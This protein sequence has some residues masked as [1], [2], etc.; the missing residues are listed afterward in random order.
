MGVEKRLYT[1]MTRPRY[2]LLF[3]FSIALIPRLLVWTIIPID[4]NSDSYHHW[5]ISYLTLKIGLKQGRLWD[6]NGCEFYWGVVPHLVQAFILGALFTPSLLPYR[7]LNLM[8]GCVNSYLVYLIG[9]D[10]FYWEVGFYAGILFALYPVAAVFD[11]VALQETLALCLALL[12]IQLFKS[13]PGLSG[14]LLALA[15]QSRTEFWLVSVF[16]V[17]GVVL[18]ER[19]TMRVQPFV[20]GWLAVTSLFCA[21]FRNWTSNPFYPLYW[22]LYNVF[23]GWTQ[24]GR[25]LPFHTLMLNWI[26]DKIQ[27]WLAKATGQ[28]LLGSMITL[29]G[30][31]L[32][33]LR[34][35]WRR[36][37]VYLFFL[38]VAVVFSPIFLT[39]Y[40]SHGQSL[41][42]MLRMSIPIAAFGSIPLALILYRLKMKLPTTW[43][44]RLPLELTLLILAVNSF[45]YLVPSYSRFQEGT[46]IA[47][48]VADAAYK[49]YAG[50]TLVCDNPTMNYRFVTRWRLKATSLLGNHYSP[51]YYGVS[52]PIRYAE[53]FKR[54]NITL[55]L[56]TGSRS[57][58]VWAVTS[59]DLP[60]LLMLKEEAHGVRVYEVDQELLD[61]LLMSRGPRD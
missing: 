44:R 55:W 61:E 39:Y 23:G 41:L 31:F 59:R 28:V 11:V 42:Y 14:I 26:S 3:F 60:G 40:P 47:F 32:H 22:S 38:T 9:R 24:R 4:W 17:A 19:L 21:L 20:L 8:L 25:G 43:L 30:S 52:S 15:A 37:H 51:H 7:L 54:N 18:I 13:R 53:W 12:S 5:Q 34:R 58:P 35:P 56:H 29:S 45:C 49:H 6:L 46:I 2:T 1:I 36:Y 48:E 10:N 57:H 27:A 16:F 50:G 33:M